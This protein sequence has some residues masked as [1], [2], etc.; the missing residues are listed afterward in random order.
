MNN[1]SFLLVVYL[2]HTT[3]NG[4]EQEILEV[5]VKVIHQHFRMVF[6]QTM[7]LIVLEM[8]PTIYL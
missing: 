6:Y 1:D 8:V 7:F 2:G 3:G 4:L 5:G